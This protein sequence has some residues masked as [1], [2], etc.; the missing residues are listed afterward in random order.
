MLVSYAI[1][2]AEIF[3]DSAT[4]EAFTESVLTFLSARMGLSRNETDGYIRVVA[5]YAASVAVV[6]DIDTQLLCEALEGAPLAALIGSQDEL[7][8]QPESIEV[9]EGDGQA[10]LDCAALLPSSYAP[11]PPVQPSADDEGFVPWN[12]SSKGLA[13]DDADD[14]QGAFVVAL[15]ASGA[16]VVALLLLLLLACWRYPHLR[17]R[18]TSRG[19]KAR[20][21][22]AK[23]GFRTVEV[24]AY[25]S[26][27]WLRGT[28][29]ANRT[30]TTAAARASP[31]GARGEGTEPVR[32][33]RSR[34]AVRKPSEV[35]VALAAKP[36]L[37][38]D[39]I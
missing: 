39:R 31:T 4:R 18:F 1:D 25:P 20:R 8:Y 19:R 26:P 15:A 33:A 12:E 28:L 22:V 14:S 9:Q 30:H 38:Y 32:P 27:T 10:P 11:A 36:K 5:M 7:D 17:R 24:T 37:P 21:T 16:V 3:G 6:V 35:N 29:D 23:G 2:S 13:T 34:I